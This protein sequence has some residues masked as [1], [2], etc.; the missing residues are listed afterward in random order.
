MYGTLPIG[1]C[2]LMTNKTDLPKQEQHRAVQGGTTPN[3]E[4]KNEHLTYYALIFGACIV[5]IIFC[6]VY[7]NYTDLESKNTY[8]I[9]GSIILLSG[10]IYIGYRYFS[11]EK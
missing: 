1:V 7:A 4:E 10:L 2:G 3:V 5:F 11:K 9:I 8:L 6:I